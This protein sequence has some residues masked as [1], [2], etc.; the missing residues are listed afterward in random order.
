VPNAPKQKGTAWETAVVRYLDASGLPARRKALA[1][2]QDEGDIEVP[3]VPGVVIEAKNCKGQSL[4]QWVDEVTAEAANAK[5]VV[6]AV[7]HHRRNY[8][9]PGKGYV[10]LSGEHFTGLLSE[11]RELRR[12]VQCLEADIDWERHH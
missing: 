9:S 11:L 2:S 1:G 8:A 10:T 12:K 4:A 5:A 6:G 7:W 3:S